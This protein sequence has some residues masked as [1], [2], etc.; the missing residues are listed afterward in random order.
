MQKRGKKA[1]SIVLLGWLGLASPVAATPLVDGVFDAASGGEWD[2]YATEDDGYLAPGVGGQA[3]DV[4]YLG[5]YFDTQ[6]LYFGLQTGFDIINGRDYTPTLHFNPGDFALDTDNDGDFDYA[7]DFS[8]DV[9]D[10]F[11]GFTLVDMRQL[12]GD[13][14]WVQSEYAQHQAIADPVEAVYGSDD[15]V[16][17]TDASSGAF[18]T[19]GTIDGVDKS[20]ILEGRLS[21]SLFDYLPGDSMTVHWTMGCGNDVIEQTSSAAPVPEPAT[22]MLL[23]TGLAGLAGGLRKKRR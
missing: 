5:L 23:A 1:L 9:N 13:T 4:E 22:M 14:Y 11:A 19:V 10:A 15:V 18:G 6:Y 21:L 2:G 17:A 16:V 12:D 20:Y 8:F 3:Y 7:V